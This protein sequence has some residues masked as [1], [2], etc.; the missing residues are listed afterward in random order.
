MDLSDAGWA[1]I[2]AFLPEARNRTTATMADAR[3]WARDLL[4]AAARD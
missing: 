2:A 4:C 1:L 3:N